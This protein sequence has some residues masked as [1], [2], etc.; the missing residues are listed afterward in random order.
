MIDISETSYQLGGKLANIHMFTKQ[1]S[2]QNKEL[3]EGDSIYTSRVIKRAVKPEHNNN[4]NYLKI[5]RPI[6]IS[7]VKLI[8]STDKKEKGNKRVKTN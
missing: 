4:E 1:K 2:L 5:E 3:F 7:K 8:N 6:F